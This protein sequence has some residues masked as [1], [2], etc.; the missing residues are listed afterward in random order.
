MLLCLPIYIN[1]Y[2]YIYIQRK[3]MVIIRWLKRSFYKIYCQ[4]M[5]RVRFNKPG[6]LSE[7]DEK[8]RA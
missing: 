6:I 4:N 1:I 7:K 3:R 8:N 2:I 5:R